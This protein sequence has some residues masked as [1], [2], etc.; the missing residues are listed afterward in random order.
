MIPKIIHYCWF[1]G[2]AKPANIQRCIDSW[3]RLMPDYEIRCWDGNSFDFDSVAYTR[4][5]MAVRQYAHASDYVRLYALYTEGGIYLD[6]DVEV[7]K[8]FDDL[9]ND[10]FFTGIESFPTYISKHKFAGTCNHLQAAIMGSEPNHPFLKD[11]LD[12]YNNL[13]FR[14]ADGSIDLLEIPRRITNVMAN[15]GLVEENKLQHLSEGITVYPNNIIA[16]SVEGTVPPECYA[17]HW[18]VKS[19]GKENA[20]R[21]KFYKFCWNHDLMPLYH[22]VERFTSRK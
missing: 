8:R 9:L 18:G 13:H 5:A 14:K 17:F 7:F 20:K 11:C 15:Y 3:Q 22:F 21:G 10:R 12:L 1:S 16:N 6:T 4:E 19:W 2:D